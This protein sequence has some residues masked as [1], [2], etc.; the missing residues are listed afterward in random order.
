MARAQGPGDTSKQG[1]TGG[2]QQRRGPK[3]GS[4]NPQ[5]GQRPGQPREQGEEQGGQRRTGQEGGSQTTPD[6]DKDRSRKGGGGGPKRG[7]S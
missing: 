4:T 1:G 6:R 2:D 5:E 3:P 7:N